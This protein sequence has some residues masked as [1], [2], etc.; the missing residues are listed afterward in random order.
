L[1]SRLFVEPLHHAFVA[2]FALRPQGPCT[3]RQAEEK[4]HRPRVRC[5]AAAIPGTRFFKSLGGIFSRSAGRV[6]FSSRF[7]ARV[8]R[9]R[10]A[11]SFHRSASGFTSVAARILCL[12][13]RRPCTDVHLRFRDRPDGLAAHLPADLDFPSVARGSL[14]QVLCQRRICKNPASSDPAVFFSGTCLKISN[15]T[16]RNPLSLASSV[17]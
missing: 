3:N 16:R 5:L 10:E 12:G 14:V 13:Q 8:L 4:G 15:R 1:S 7:C 9:A 17:A 2:G 11:T 6:S